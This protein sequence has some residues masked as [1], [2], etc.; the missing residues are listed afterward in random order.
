MGRKI[1]KGILG[2]AASVFTLGF[3]DLAQG[4]QWGASV[5]G[6]VDPAVTAAKQAA[7][8]AA[9]QAI[10]DG[11]A[12]ALKSNSALDNTV[13]AVVGG[14]ADAADTGTDLRRRR[15]GSVSSTLGI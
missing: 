12:N 8:Q 15:A 10:I 7:E 5:T 13:S 1:K 4:K 2:K 11:N 6:A 3:S 9:Q 14:G